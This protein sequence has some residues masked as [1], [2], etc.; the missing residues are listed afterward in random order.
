M[1]GNTTVL[2]YQMM[3]ENHL[4]GACMNA[5]RSGSIEMAS[6]YLETY[7]TFIKCDLTNVAPPFNEKTIGENR[8]A[9]IN[10]YFKL[11]KKV[12]KDLAKNIEDVR[13]KYQDKN[14]DIPTITIK[15]R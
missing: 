15:K 2:S 5:E 3:I 4:L 14:A 12:G 6:L 1:A 9:W 13:S 7:A 10:Y 8:Q 11:W